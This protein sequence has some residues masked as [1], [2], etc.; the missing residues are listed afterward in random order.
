MEADMK[1]V[2]GGYAQGKLQYVLHQGGPNEDF[3]A[4]INECDGGKYTPKCSNTCYEK[5][6]G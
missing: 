1:L 6:Y 3:E 2:I 5:I 4:C